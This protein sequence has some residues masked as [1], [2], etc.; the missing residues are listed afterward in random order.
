MR[1]VLL[2]LVL[3]LGA[4][5]RVAVPNVDES[6]VGTVSETTIPV[7][8]EEVVSEQPL[9][10]TVETVSEVVQ[11]PV[12]AAIEVLESLTPAAVPPPPANEWE[13]ACREAAA[14]LIIRWEVTSPSY[15]T[16]SLL[17]PI[18]PGGASGVTW[19]IGYDGG[20]QT[21]SVIS[22]DWLAH[23]DRDRLT[24]TAGITGTKAK[25]ELP[26]FRDI[27]TSYSYASQVFE[28]RSLI[29]YMRRTERAFGSENFRR[30]NPNACG[31]L[32]SLVYNRGAAMTGDSRREMKNIRDV[33]LG[34][35]PNYTCIA[36]EIRSMSRLW[37]G[38]VNERGLTARRESEAILAETPHRYSQ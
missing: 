12:Q 6:K 16:R 5:G 18:W 24:N 25:T 15:Y 32:V 13:A 31:A 11:P 36:Q 19:G 37:R 23:A 34:P 14:P 29:E 33:C 20:H 2:S 35:T 30:L 4:C 38:T 7:V 27:Q 9:P 26:Q 8:V 28:D 21:R 17:Y 22:G 10:L 1:L 3:L